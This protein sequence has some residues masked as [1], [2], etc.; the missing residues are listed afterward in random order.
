[1][2]NPDPRPLEER[3]EAYILPEPNS[4]CWLWIGG[5]TSSGYGAFWRNGKTVLA[6]RVCYEIHKGQVPRELTLDHLCRNTACVNPDH[7]EA[8]TIKENTARGISPPAKNVK[9][10][11]CHRGHE[12]TDENTHLQVGKDGIT[13]RRCRVCSALND[14]VRRNGPHNN[15]YQK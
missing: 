4:G 2:A 10:T 3:F 13:R 5:I 8:V 11:H 14:R 1:M 15:G 7:L 9:K 12:F 6:H